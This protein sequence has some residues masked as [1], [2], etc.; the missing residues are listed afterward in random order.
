MISHADKFFTMKIKL[1]KLACIHQW[2]RF[3]F[4]ETQLGGAMFRFFFFFLSCNQINNDV[5]YIKYFPNS[6]FYVAQGEKCVGTSG[7]VV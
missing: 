5:I 7:M 2:L 4:Q 1:H 6:G 3:S